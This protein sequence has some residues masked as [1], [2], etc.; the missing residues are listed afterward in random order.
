MPRK[1]PPPEAS[2]EQQAEAHEKAER[3]LLSP[4]EYRVLSAGTIWDNTLT[5]HNLTVEERMFCHSYIIDRNEIAAL[6]RL[7]IE[8]TVDQLRRRAKKL[9]ANTEV[10]A[11]IDV[12]GKRV[13]DALQITAERVNERIAAVAFFD[14][15]EVVQADHNGLRLLHTSLWRRDQAWAISSIEMGQHGLKLKMHDGLRAAEMLGKQLGTIRDDGVE[16]AAA[17]SRAAAEAVVGKII[18][19]F[20]RTAPHNPANQKRIAGPETQH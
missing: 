18:E 1:K 6:K 10:L 12:L 8:G 9:L 16:A 13:C 2:D 14:P 20:E 11:C 19:V 17:A 7:N 3:Q 5:D 15:R 4:E